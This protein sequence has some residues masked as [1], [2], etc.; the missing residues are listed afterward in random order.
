MLMK[1]PLKSYDTNFHIFFAS[2]YLTTGSIPGTRKWYAD[3]RKPPIH[4]FLSNGSRC[5]R[6]F[7]G[8]IW[9][10]WPCNS[11][12]SC[13]WLSASIALPSYG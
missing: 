11:R 2:H 8:W 7:S 3:F 5:C 4:R 12:P 10:I 9:L 1:L 6:I 13:C